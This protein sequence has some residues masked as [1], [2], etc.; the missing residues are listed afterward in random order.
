MVNFPDKNVRADERDSTNWSKHWSNYVVKLSKSFQALGHYLM[1]PN[2]KIDF[3][4]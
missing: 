2:F 4:P 3:L 1:T